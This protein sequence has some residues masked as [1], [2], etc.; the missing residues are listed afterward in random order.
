MLTQ[1]WV[2]VFGLLWATAAVGQSAHADILNAQGQKIGTAEIRASGILPSRK[3][4]L[5]AFH[6]QNNIAAQC[7]RWVER[8]LRQTRCPL[9]QPTFGV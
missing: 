7:P 4:S 2:L 9:S 1:K 8:S 3:Q 5:M 6:S